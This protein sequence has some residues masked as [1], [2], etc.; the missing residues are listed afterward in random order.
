[1]TGSLAVWPKSMG[2]YAVRWTALAEKALARMPV[3]ARGA[4]HK[5]ANEIATVADALKLPAVESPGV[6]HFEVPGHVVNYLV[7]ETSR[8]LTVLSVF[9]SSAHNSTSDT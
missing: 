8:I 7:D 4:V 9:S 6:L 3:A 2:T 5:L 1:M